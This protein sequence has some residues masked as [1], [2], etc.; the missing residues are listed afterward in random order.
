MRQT[1]MDYVNSEIK[2]VASI[3]ESL[4]ADYA[5]L[6][7]GSER[8]EEL[9]RQI[10]FTEGIST[11]LNNIVRRQERP[12]HSLS[13]WEIADTLYKHGEMDAYKQMVEYIKGM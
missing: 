11:A 8:K 12:T 4:L 2:R 9:V 3:K 6:E 10:H 5:L 13:W 7:Y 1:F